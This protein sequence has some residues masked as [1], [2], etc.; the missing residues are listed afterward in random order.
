M[1]KRQ[2]T[3]EYPGFTSRQVQ[4]A[5]LIVVGVI[6]FL[7]YT[8][9]PLRPQLGEFMV[10]QFTV[11]PV[12]I[13]LGATLTQ[14]QTKA[15]TIALILGG[16]TVAW[17]SLAQCA[18]VL[19]WEDSRNLSMLWAAYLLAFPFAAVT[20]DG[21][22]RNGLWI[23]GGAAAACSLAAGI[24][25][26]LLM[27]DALP[28]FLKSIIVWDKELRL[29]AFSHPNIGG[30]MLMIGIAFTVTFGVQAKKKWLRFG[31]WTLAGVEL[32][33]MALA[34]SRASTLMTCAF[35]GGVIFFSIW[36]KG[37]KQFLT[38]LLAAVIVVVGL[39]S[40]STVVYK[41]NFAHQMEVLQ[42]EAA[43]R[44]AAEKAAEAVQTPEPTAPE[45]ADETDAAAETVQA[46]SDQE[47]P[48]E[49]TAAEEAVQ[50]EPVEEEQMLRPEE[51][52][53]RRSFWTDLAS[54]TGRTGI[55][56]A[57]IQAVKDNPTILLRGTTYISE[58]VKAGGNS[59]GVL[60]THNAWLE[61][62][63]AFGLPGLLM[64]LIFTAMSIWGIVRVI[65]R[66]QRDIIQVC[67]A[68]IA[69]CMLVA[70][71]L[72][73]FLFTSYIYCHFYPVIFFL[74]NGYLLVWQKKP[75]RD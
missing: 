7:L 40:L 19:A 44:E 60:H 3:L 38:G 31:L 21:E 49:E 4:I 20:Q 9:N 25:G 36:K 73:P 41:A 72:E 34:N 18:Q 26:I 62:L 71:I 12:L 29:V 24:G 61:M 66:Q 45:A 2:R 63:L 67:V 43:E 42:Q 53:K 65:F 14:R 32:A 23:L 69:G 39:F 57:G 75:E 55:W 11:V 17:M 16:I 47:V 15:G 51:V 5:C 10:E 33:V 59:F 68:M 74:C 46:D 28:N 52:S 22:R 1:S 70:G 50:N 54:L 6:E 64:A 35:I 58:A 37:W 56:K 13:F 8:V 30:W 27:L 48:L